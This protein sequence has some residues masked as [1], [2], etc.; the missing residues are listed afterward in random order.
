MRIMV[1]SACAEGYI[2]VEPNDH[3]ASQSE[4][5]TLHLSQILVMQSHPLRW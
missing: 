4:F 2:C 3:A 5:T 1:D